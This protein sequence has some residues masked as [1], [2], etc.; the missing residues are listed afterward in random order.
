MRKVL[1]KD[2]LMQD[3]FGKIEVNLE[4]SE[5]FHLDEFQIVIRS[6]IFYN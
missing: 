6:S 3:I 5:I 1:D 4:E 2:N